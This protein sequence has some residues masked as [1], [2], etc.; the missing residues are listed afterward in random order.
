MGIIVA[1]GV[2]SGEIAERA[3]ERILDRW[4][5][6][7]TARLLLW[8]REGASMAAGRIEQRTRLHQALF[9]IRAGFADTLWLPSWEVLGDSWSRALVCAE[10]WL[11]GG[12]VMVNGSIIEG[13]G[14]EGDVEHEVATAMEWSRLCAHADPRRTVQEGDAAADIGECRSKW[15]PE[16]PVR[17]LL[18]DNLW[19]HNVTTSLHQFLRLRSN[20]CLR[21]AP[22]LALSRLGSTTGRRPSRAWLATPWSCTT[23]CCMGQRPRCSSRNCSSPEM[24]PSS[25]RCR[26]SPRSR[27]AFSLDRSA[28]CS[29]AAM[30]IE[31]GARRRYC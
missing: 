7:S 21:A 20:T 5:T 26:A 30:A 23:S 14:A 29:S 1:Y 4:V 15:A 25:P 13:A 27:W 19:S 9:C 18:T 31:W 8:R 12:D 10:V 11:A 16:H 28:G 22:L 6:S 2:R 3:E 24:T 17:Y